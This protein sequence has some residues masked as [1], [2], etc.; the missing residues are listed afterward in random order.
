MTQKACF[1]TGLFLLLFL[2]GASVT[3]SAS[4]AGLSSPQDLVLLSEDGGWCWF[5][6]PRAVIVENRLIV[7]IVASGHEDASRKGDIRALVYDLVSGQTTEVELADQLQLDDHDSPV[8]LPLQGSGIVALWSLHGNENRFYYRFSKG[9]NPDQ[10]EDTQFHIASDSSRVTY[11]NPFQLPDEGNRIYNFFRGLDNSF[12]PSYAYSDDL[13]KTWTTGA[14]FIDVPSEFRHR[15]YVK[16]ASNGVDT[17]HMLYTEGHPRN[18]DNSIYHLLYRDGMLR[19]SDGEPIAPLSEGLSRPEEGTLVFRGDPENVAWTVD[20]ELDGQG[21]PFAV[22]SVQVG[23]SGIPDRQGGLDHRYRLASWS[24]SSWHEEEIAYAGQRLYP[25]E[26]DYTGL[27]ALI[28]GHP[29]KVY[30]STD[31]HPDS[32]KPLIS[33]TDG[34]RHYEIFKGTPGSSNEWIWEP[35]TADSTQ[36]N[37]R[38]IVPHPKDGRT[39]LLWL[40]GEYRTYTDYSLAVVGIPIAAE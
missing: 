23:S 20:I 15:P 37:L 21:R 28:P 26:D 35:I 30:I 24:G 14:V 38:P 29:D 33:R 17:V 22:Y 19:R 3:G 5:E 2:T 36:D 13:G 12:K 10:W 25:G 32:G 7:G 18:Y 27:A 39:V 34:K 4:E 6:D 1:Q 9:D 16:Y 31:A 8:F 11:S 40:R